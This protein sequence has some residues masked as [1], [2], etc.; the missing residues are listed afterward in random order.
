MFFFYRMDMLF[1]GSRDFVM[2]FLGIGF[3]PEEEVIKEYRDV[4][5]P[6][7]LPI[8]DMVRYIMLDNFASCSQ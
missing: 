7:Y 4:I 5:L 8:F 6:K 1:E 3:R 2:K